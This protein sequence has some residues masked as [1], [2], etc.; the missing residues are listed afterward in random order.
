MNTVLLLGGKCVF[1]LIEA[2]S[3]KIFRNTLLAGGNAVDAAISSMF[4]VGVMDS[5]SSGLG[6]GHF[7]T[8][9]NASV[10]VIYKTCC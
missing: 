4:C 1:F 7:M 8:I 6:G 5:H 3:F 2:Y 9:Y 10:F